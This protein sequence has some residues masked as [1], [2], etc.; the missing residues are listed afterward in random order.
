MTSYTP[1]SCPVCSESG[2]FHLDTP[3]AEVR[4]NIPA[5]LT[6]KGHKQLRKEGQ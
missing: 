4:A 6:R 3:H 2:G 1:G 5:H